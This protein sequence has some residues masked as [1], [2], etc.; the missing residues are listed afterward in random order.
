MHDWSKIKLTRLALLLGLL[1]LAAPVL[2]ANE[3]HYEAEI[4]NID[5]FIQ[6]GQYLL[7]ADLSYQLSPKAMEALQNG[8]S[9]LWTVHLRLKLP[10]AWIGSKTLAEMQIRYR[11]QYQAL[12]NMFRVTNEN[13]GEKRNY[14][15]LTAALEA[16]SAIRHLSLINKDVVQPSQHPEIEMKISFERDTLPLPLRLSAYVN[17][18][19]YLSSDWTTWPLK[20]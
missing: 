10:N 13:L 6:D 2:Q 16:M 20:K 3:S 5:V 12:L 17:Q 19:W 11:L 18:Q 7:S 4:K 1:L 9:L 14:S 15:S 8:V